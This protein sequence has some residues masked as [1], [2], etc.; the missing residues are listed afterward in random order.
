MPVKRAREIAR[1]IAEGL[2][3][4]HEKG[5]VHRDVKPENVFLTKDGHAKV[6]DFGLAR[7][8][9]TVRSGGDGRSPTVSVLTVAGTAVGS[10]AYMSPEQT[11]G[12]SVDHR[13][14]Q[15]SLGI[16]LYGMMSGRRPVRG[17]SAAEVLAA[18]IRDEPEPLETVDPSAPFPVCLL[19]ERLLAKDPAERWDSIRDL[20][21]DLN[22]WA[23]RGGEK[24][25]ATGGPA[26]GASAGP[27][28]P[29]R[30][31]R[32]PRRRRL[33]RRR[34]GPGGRLPGGTRTATVCVPFVGRRR[35]PGGRLPDGTQDECAGAHGSDA[36]P[37][38]L[39]ADVGARV[40][41]AALSLP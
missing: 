5:I 24:V 37:E 38:A 31:T 11:R 4:A 21:R 27:A 20:A 9:A 23:H 35:G 34:R 2:A 1:E 19:V 40:R 15:F 39:P 12:L 30:R 28:G 32:A 41:D 33:P 13:S 16:L 10:V 29:R 7:S 17:D 6:P 26:A 8:G 36:F 18:L 3:A 25:I 14:D 22:T